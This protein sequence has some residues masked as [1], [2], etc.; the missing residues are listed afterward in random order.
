MTNLGKGEKKSFRAL[1]L[2]IIHYLDDNEVARRDDLLHSVAS[3]NPNYSDDIVDDWIKK[4]HGQ[5]LIKVG[6]GRYSDVAI[7]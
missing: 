5:K 3:M 1:S 6:Q 4:M 7:A 2:K